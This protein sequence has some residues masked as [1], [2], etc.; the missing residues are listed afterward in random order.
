MIRLVYELEVAGKLDITF[1]TFNQNFKN[2]IDKS[3][4]YLNNI[5]DKKDIPVPIIELTIHMLSQ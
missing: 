5:H 4:E 2:K 1:P 3:L